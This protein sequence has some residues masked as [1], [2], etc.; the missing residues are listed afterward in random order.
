VDVPFGIADASGAGSLE[1]ILS[2]NSGSFALPSIQ[3]SGA[4]TKGRITDMY[5][6][7]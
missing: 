4:A 1:P 7:R 5:V 3:K 2:L 6:S